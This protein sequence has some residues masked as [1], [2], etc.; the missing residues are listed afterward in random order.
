MISDEFR[1]ELIDILKDVISQVIVSCQV[2][3]DVLLLGVLSH[4]S[5]RL[6]EFS[7]KRKN[8]HAT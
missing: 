5:F 7:I 1:K 8:D 2:N 6:Q 3:E 4:L